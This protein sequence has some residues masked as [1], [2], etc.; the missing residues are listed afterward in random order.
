MLRQTIRKPVKENSFVAAVKSFLHLPPPRQQQN[1]QQYP[2]AHRFG[3]IPIIGHMGKL[4][5]ALWSEKHVYGKFS[6][7]DLVTLKQIPEL[8][9]HIPHYWRISYIDEVW[10]GCT[11]SPTLEAPESIIVQVPNEAYTVSFR[12]SA[13]VLRQLTDKELQL[14][15]LQNRKVG[16]KA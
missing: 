9:N 10:S 16:G 4:D 15:L 1:P 5:F 11:W 13:L 3:T 7:G 14:V 12:K 6:V 8:E 2:Q